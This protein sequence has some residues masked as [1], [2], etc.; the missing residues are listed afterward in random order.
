MCQ[1]KRCTVHPSWRC[2]HKV[3]KTQGLCA[4]TQLHI[5]TGSRYNPVALIAMLL[6]VH[7][8]VQGC[9]RGSCQRIGQSRLCCQHQPPAARYLV[10]CDRNHNTDDLCL[11]HL[12]LCTFTQL[13]GSS[14][15]GI[16]LHN[17]N[18]PLSRLSIVTD[19]CIALHTWQQQN[20]TSRQR[21]S[22]TIMTGL[23]E[24]QDICTTP[25]NKQ[26]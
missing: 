23:Q 6:L 24:V 10:M 14:L 3:F 9:S 11:Y 2:R 8:A 26:H 12:I 4:T 20:I 17:R 22:S 18:V 5:S 21:S 25:S 7:V 19:D 16:Q 1:L 13:V 15:P